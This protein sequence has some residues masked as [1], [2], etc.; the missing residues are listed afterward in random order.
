M[1]TG[2]CNS[3][4][5]YLHLQLPVNSVDNLADMILLELSAIAVFF[6]EAYSINALIFGQ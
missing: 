6:L 1:L 4:V 3:C 2:I 5:E